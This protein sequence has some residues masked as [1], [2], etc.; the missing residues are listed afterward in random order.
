MEHR[1]ADDTRR[2]EGGDRIEVQAAHSESR[3]AACSVRGRRLYGRSPHLLGR[4]GM[5]KL[6]VTGAAPLGRLLADAMHGSEAIAMV[7]PLD[8]S[9]TSTLVTELIEAGSLAR[10][11]ARWCSPPVAGGRPWSISLTIPTFHDGAL[12]SL[13][14]GRQQ[15]LHLLPVLVVAQCGP[16]WLH[17]SPDGDATVIDHPVG[18]VAVTPLACWRTLADDAPAFWITTEMADDFRLVWTL[19]KDMRHAHGV[20]TQR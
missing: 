2:G 10:V 5:L 13:R 3:T 7:T 11:E 6:G 15:P 14:L 16:Y 8:D 12:V 4:A 19:Q 17:D 9:A 20:T 1:Q 18:G